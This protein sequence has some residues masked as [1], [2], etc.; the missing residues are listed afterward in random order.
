MNSIPEWDEEAGATPILGK[1]ESRKERPTHGHVRQGAEHRTRR[2]RLLLSLVLKVCP[3]LLGYRREI[4][5]LQREQNEGRGS[6]V[7][8]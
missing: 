3:C 8:E 2:P 1:T 7:E 5:L 6:G 4:A